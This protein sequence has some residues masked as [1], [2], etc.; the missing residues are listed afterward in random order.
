MGHKTMRITSFLSPVF[1]LNFIIAVLLGLVLFIVSQ[2]NNKQR[3]I[4]SNLEKEKIKVEE[5]TNLLEAEWAYLNSPQRL[6]SILGVETKTNEA[7]IIA[8]MPKS[9]I[10]FP[11]KTKPLPE[12][13]A[14]SF[15]FKN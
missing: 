5:T 13:I 14:Y 6:S 8:A 12:K 11:P 15:N 9:I 7:T 2:E 10:L 1:I 4:L 3:V